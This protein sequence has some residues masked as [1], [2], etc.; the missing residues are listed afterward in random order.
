MAEVAVTHL[1]VDMVLARILGDLDHYLA[2]PPD[3]DLLVRG[4]ALEEAVEAGIVVAP[5]LTQGRC[6]DPG[7]QLRAVTVNEA[8]APAIV[9]T[10]AEALAGAATIVIETAVGRGL[11]AGV[12]AM[13]G[14][15]IDRG[16]PSRGGGSSQIHN[17]RTCITCDEHTMVRREFLHFLVLLRNSNCGACHLTQTGLREDAHGECPQLFSCMIDTQIATK[18]MVVRLLLPN[19]CCMHGI[20]CAH[21]RLLKQVVSIYKP[22]PYLHTL[23]SI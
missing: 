18:N 17:R 10:S 20:E 8:G 13:G 2:L 16:K 7:P 4:R 22:Y 6:R 23:T 21:M 19:L 12:M 3:Q 5:D 9:T 1:L 14:G 11:Q 15:V